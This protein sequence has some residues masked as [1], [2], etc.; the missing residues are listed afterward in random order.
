MITREEL[1]KSSDYWTEI[2]QNKIYNDLAEYIEYHNIPNKQIADILGLSKGR[3]S[4]I[5][6]GGNLNFRLDTLVKLCLSIDKIPDFQLVGVNEFIK[7]DQVNTSSI[8]FKQTETTHNTINEMLGY[9]AGGSTSKFNMSLNSFT[10]LRESF[11]LPEI[12]ST[13]S[14]AA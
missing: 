12:I 10:N 5:L 7:K 6:S 1:L 2:I 11:S 9:N 3:V 4:Q 8:I 13:G 14:K